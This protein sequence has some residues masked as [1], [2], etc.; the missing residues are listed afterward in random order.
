[1]K[2]VQVFL[3]WFFFAVVF[4][5]AGA[6]V[7]QSVG[8]IKSYRGWFVYSYGEQ[9]LISEVGSDSPAASMLEPKDKVVSING[10]QVK[11]ISQFIELMSKVETGSSYKV[12]VERSGELKEYTIAKV[13]VPIGAFL[14]RLAQRVVIPAIFLVCALLLFLLKPKDKK[15]LLVAIGFG[16]F[17]VPEA[18]ENFS[19]FPRWFYLF[20]LLVN[21]L[22]SLAFPIIAHIFLIFPEPQGAVKKLLRKIPKFEYY[23]YFPYFLFILPL[24]TYGNILLVVAPAMIPQ[25]MEKHWLLVSMVSFTGFAYMVAA[26]LFLLI[27]Y[28]NSDL[29]GQRKMKVVLTGTV[30]GILPWLILQGFVI[31]LGFLYPFEPVLPQWRP[32]LE[33]VGVLSVITIP[34]IPLSFAYA[35]IRHQVIPVS[36]IIRRGVRYLFVSRGFI[37]IEAF[38]LLGLLS[39]LLTGSRFAVIEVI[40]VRP[41][42]LA[43]VATTVFL[44]F[45]IRWLNQRIMPTIDKAFFRESYDS[46]KILTELGQ[47]VRDVAKTEQIVELAATKIQ[48]ALHTE[49]V[50]IFLKDDLQGD[51]IARVSCSYTS[52]GRPAEVVQ[53]EEIKPLKLSKDSFVVRRMQNLSIPLKIDFEDY[54]VWDRAMLALSP[55]EVEARRKE[56]QTL[57]SLGSTLLLPLMTKEEL[58]GFIS[59]GPRLADLPFSKE[60]KQLL[61]AVAW[62][63]AFAIENAK[64]ISR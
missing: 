50:T 45:S 16:L 57:Q 62:Q 41:Y 51:Y 28:I 53:S 24:V 46:Q 6:N 36:V 38:L 19:V 2:K 12:V 8:L 60:D 11:G 22:T 4:L 27:N 34:L 32:F 9:L 40:G 20:L 61:M 52:D 29:L 55:A 43:T 10:M 54:E 17:G 15:A 5:Y 35:V 18:F 13:S 56:S 44:V 23:L 3:I 48:D 31:V 63:M 37:V 64:L 42:I 59:L 1:M 33:F 25:V 21:S 49:N 26:L 39:F 47:A 14:L 30:V 58:L 7:Y